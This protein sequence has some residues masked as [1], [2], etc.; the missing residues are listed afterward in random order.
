MH[1]TDDIP[2]PHLSIIVP[3][4]NEAG[5]LGELLADLLPCQRRGCEVILVDGGSQ[6]G[7][8]HMARCAGFTVLD[9]PRGRAR[10]MNAGAAAAT[11]EVLLFLH[12]DTRLPADADALIA[13]A[14]QDCGRAWGRFDVRITGRP[15]MLKVV[16]R[17]VNL[18]SRLS[19][20]ATGDQA[21][22]VCARS[23]AQVGGFPDQPLME[24]VELSRRLKRLSR[25]ACLTTRVITSGRRWE[26]RGVWRTIVLMWRLRLAYWLGVAPD[27]LAKAYR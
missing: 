6:D 5:A 18:R 13:Q 11:G 23:F 17:M 4:L 27:Q 1:D 14:M 15:L 8:P 10:Q 21:M 19:G 20:I 2:P 22:F 24:D 26:S 7:S 9:A 12:A 16:A 25:P 3:M